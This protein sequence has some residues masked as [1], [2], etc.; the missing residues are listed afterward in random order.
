MTMKS[1]LILGLLF[2]GCFLAINGLQQQKPPDKNHQGT[3]QARHPLQESEERRAGKQ[4]VGRNT[5]FACKMYQEI[6]QKSKD[7]NLFFSPLSA[8]TGFSML[9]LGAK[10]YTLSQLSESL[11]LRN[12]PTKSIYEGFHYIIHSLNKPDRDLKLHLGNTLFIEDQLTVQKRFLNDVKSIYETEAIPVDL[13]DPQKAIT[14]I[15]DYVSQKTHG[16]INHLIKNLDQGMMLLLIGH[17]YFQAEWEKK[18]NPKDTK[19][20]DFFL[21][22]GKSVKVPMMYRGGKYKTAYDDQ[23]CCTILEIPF[24]G[25]MTGLFILPDKGKLKRVEEGLNKNKLTQWR[26]SLKCSPVDVSMPKFTISGTYDMKKCLSG[27][28]VTRIFDGSAEL[29]KI[30]PQKTLKVSQAIHRAVLKMDE[31]GAEAAGGTGIET[32]PMTIPQV[33]KFNQPF[34]MMVIDNIT[35]S[36]LFMGKIMNPK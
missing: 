7:E 19:E 9:T 14:Q 16:K 10:D 3:H 27:L 24:T 1:T 6:T 22:N 34:V 36:L 35:Q 18:F 32:L 5:E 12:V 26:Q 4:I 28:G 11:N 30:S 20:D 33:L 29:T 2:A 21:I 8:S 23:L 17:I 31:K 15:N 25:N 13:K